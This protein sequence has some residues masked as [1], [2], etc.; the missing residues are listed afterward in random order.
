MGRDVRMW[1]WAGLVLIGRTLGRCGRGPSSIAGTEG[2]EEFAG[3]DGTEHS[4][5]AE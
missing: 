2:N 4:H 5:I 1:G 3:T